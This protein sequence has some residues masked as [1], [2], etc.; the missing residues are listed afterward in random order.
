MTVNI[1][2]AR[3]MGSE[4]Y[5]VDHP[6][7]LIHQP[8]SQGSN[9]HSLSPTRDS[10]VGYSSPP[11]IE[12]EIPYQHLLSVCPITHQ[13]AK[14][15]GLIP[16][17]QHLPYASRKPKATPTEVVVSSME[18]VVLST[19]EGLAEAIEDGGEPLVFR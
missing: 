2:S 19:V 3:R 12:H 9:S 4:L 1:S 11:N 18:E 17:I 7:T 16:G 8:S 14:A 6:L 13:F 10:A 15:V 5:M